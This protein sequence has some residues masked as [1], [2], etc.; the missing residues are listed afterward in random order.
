MKVYI[1]KVNDDGKVVGRKLVNVELISETTTTVKVK[2]A[3][4]DI[5]TRKKSRDLVQEEGK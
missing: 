4:G 1:N 2:L 3:D 5:I